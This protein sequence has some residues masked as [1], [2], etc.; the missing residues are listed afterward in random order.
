MLKKVNVVLGLMVGPRPHLHFPSRRNQPAKA[1]IGPVL[2]G[3]AAATCMKKADVHVPA[4][5][6]FVVAK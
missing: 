4:G 5:L 1:V 3:I 2:R 6:Q